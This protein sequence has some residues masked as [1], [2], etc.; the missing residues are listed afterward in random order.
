MINFFND[1][2]TFYEI[3]C[4]NSCQ[5]LVNGR[6]AKKQ[7]PMTDSA[8]AYLTTVKDAF[9]DD[10]E[11]YDKFL[12]LVKNFTA[13]RFNLVRGIEEV[14]ELLKGYRDLILGFNVFLP[15]GYEIK[16]PLEDEQPPEKKLDV[17]VK[18]KKLLHKIKARFHGQDNVYKTFLAILKMHKD[19]TKSPTAAYGEI[20]A[21]LQH[22]ADLLNELPFLSLNTSRTISIHFTS[23]Q[24]SLF[25]E[26][27]SAV[28][29]VQQMCVLK[30]KRTKTS[31]DDH[32]HIVGHR[33]ESDW[34]EREK[35]NRDYYQDGIQK[36]LSLKRTHFC[37]A[38]DLM[39]RS[40][41][42]VDKHFGMH[43]MPSTCYDQSS[44]KSSERFSFCAKIKDKLQNPKNY[45]SKHV[46]I[47]S[48][49]KTTRQELPS[50]TTD[51]PRKFPDLMKGFNECVT[52]CKKMNE[53]SRDEE[54]VQK[55]IKLEDWNRDRHHD[56]DDRVKETVSD[57][58]KRDKSTV[59]ANKNVSGRKLSLYASKKKNSAKSVRELDL[60]I[61]EK[62]TPSYY[63]LPKE[64]QIP[65]SSRRTKLDAEVLNDHWKCVAPSIKDYSSKH[66]SKNLNEMTLFECEDDRIELDMCLETAKSTTK[67]VE[68]L[69]EKINTNMIER[70]NPINIEKHLIAQNLRCIEQLYGD[71]GIDVL[72]VLRKNASQVLP[73]ILTRL[74]QKH[75][76]WARCRADLNKLWAE[77]YAK[78]YH[79]SLNHDRVPSTRNQEL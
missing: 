4:M 23:A 40:F 63:L 76:E 27:S 52:Q 71:H 2:Y 37:M 59:V 79:K 50:S 68:E 20:T 45:F 75:E 39:A 72:D 77:V 70:D 19:G 13:E 67:Q 57:C 58:R 66:M 41:C 1:I 42:N 69:I 54:H 18:A 64:F 22:H 29:I 33:L 28:P 11:K 61:C 44:M 46:D 53:S 55:Q 25:R 24:N 14:K 60:S 16:L 47:Y 17:F 36:L 65:S 51:F 32:N 12:E 49:E 62:C 30:R 8:L 6:G 7:R 5:P 35:D 15:K 10:R 3:F 34:S 9:K 56:G 48:K 78:N 31:H 43:P 26:K 73:V 21:L 38:E 74:K